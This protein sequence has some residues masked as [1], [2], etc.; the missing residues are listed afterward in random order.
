MEITLNHTPHE[1]TEHTTLYDIVCSQVGD[2]QKG[3]AVAVNDTVIPR[4]TWGW[5]AVQ[6]NDNILII[7]ATQGG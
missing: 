5:H 1:V 6:S 7:K 4:A 2:K 3:I